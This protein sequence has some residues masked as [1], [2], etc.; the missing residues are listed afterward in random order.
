[1]KPTAA[2]DQII[3]LYD[4]TRGGTGEVK[5]DKFILGLYQIYSED[6]E[7]DLVDSKH[8]YTVMHLTRSD[9]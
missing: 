7:F 1:M 2:F 9:T 3:D 4:K 5:R 8:Q 6:T